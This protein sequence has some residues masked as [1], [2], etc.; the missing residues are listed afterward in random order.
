MIDK[1]KDKNYNFILKKEND[2]F[3][4]IFFI[5]DNCDTVKP[6][7]NYGSTELAGV[8]CDKNDFPNKEAIE[9]YLN[10]TNNLTNY[11][12][13]SG[14]RS[15]RKS[16]RNKKSKSRIRKSKSKKYPRKWVSTVYK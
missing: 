3:H 12:F 5:R 8:I 1:L 11:T 15:K 2:I 7:L 10:E 9:T 16:R 14:L 4:C 13:L 6:N